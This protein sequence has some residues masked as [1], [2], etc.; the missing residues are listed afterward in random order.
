MAARGIG[1][2][3]NQA[4]IPALIDLLQ[5][6]QHP[7][8]AR[9]AAAQALGKLGGRLAR[10]ALERAVSETQFSVSEAALKALWLMEKNSWGS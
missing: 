6:A 4:A 9:I 2:L 5:D 1:N 8:V 7:F 3:G 10:E